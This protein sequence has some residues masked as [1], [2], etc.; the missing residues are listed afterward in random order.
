MYSN[1]RKME[2]L[3]PIMLGGTGSDVGK[4]ILATGLC[5]IFL[6]DGFQPAPFKAQN[7]ALN[8]AATPDGKEIGRAQAVQA[9]ACELCPT[10][11]M[12]PILLKPSS[13]KTSQV[14]LNG[15]VTG[16][17]NAFEFYRKEGRE[18][19]KEAVRTSFD[20]L[21]ERYNPIVME[22]AGSIAEINLKETDLVNMSMARYADAAVILVAD[23]DRGG[24]FASVYGS[25]ML[26]EEQDRKLIKG[27]IVNK[28]R[29]DMKL[30][31]EGKKMMER[32]CKIPVIGVVPF[33]DD[34][35]IDEED[36]V[37]LKEKKTEPAED[38]INIAVVKVNHISNYTD[39]LPL[40]L[41][42]EINLYYTADIEKIGKAD[43]IILPGSKS[44]IAD[45]KSLEENGIVSAIKEAS[46]KGVKIWGVCG[47]YQMLGLSIEDP[48]QQ[49]GEIRSIEGMGLLPVRTVLEGK[50]ITVKTK[51]KVNSSYCEGYE[52][53]MG[54]SE[55]INSS[56]S[57]CTK[58]NGETDGCMVKNGAVAGTYIHG[59]F[60]NRA[61][62]NFLLE[63]VTD[64]QIEVKDFKGEK[65]S[66]Y[67]LL[68]ER[69]RKYIDMET[70]Y[71][72]MK[73]DDRGTR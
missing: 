39:F 5:R 61:V 52:I 63:G 51:F 12:N 66:Q 42:P 31:D 71:K 58:S 60:E 9:E 68:A 3:R 21:N 18:I 2:K 22:G 48:D 73:R 36:S 16:N 35:R 64:K 28:F 49:E 69:L 46:A 1:L 37:A 72:I 67:N 55:I 25:I 24:V 34:I 62:I 59:L 8:S 50:K 29:G 10:T 47:G 4:S 26:Q 38:K 27:V 20:R 30:F 65:E 45:L 44:T 56:Q 23:I 41:I 54:R 57:F 70:L 14:V 17:K 15:I 11:D 43:I 32:L 19:L 6:Q 53:H 40:E 7:M 13:D 33:F